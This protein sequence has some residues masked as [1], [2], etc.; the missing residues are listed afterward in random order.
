MV[1]A[2]GVEALQL[3]IQQAAQSAG[4]QMRQLQDTNS[5]LESRMTFLREQ[6]SAAQATVRQV[7]AAKQQEVAEARSIG[8]AR[9]H[10]S[11]QCRQLPF[12]P[13]RIPHS[14]KCG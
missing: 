12:T 14:A 1:Q 2:E 8:A 3:V 4:R 7:V 13:A 9:L 10:V 5:H 6:E 11:T